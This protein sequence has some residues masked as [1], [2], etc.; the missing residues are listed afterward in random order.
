MKSINSRNKWKGREGRKKSG[1]LW[2]LLTSLAI[3]MLAT[4]GITLLISNNSLDISKS[5]IPLKALYG[6]AV[7]AGCF[8]TARK[9]MQGKLVWAALTGALTGI[10]LLVILFAL[11]DAAPASAGGL[12]GVTVAAW[13]IGGFLG[14]RRKRN[15]YE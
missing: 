13:L 8:L 11:S 4:T 14:A 5:A 7:F 12:L 15:R 10:I 1:L 2:G 9:S 6:A 3:L